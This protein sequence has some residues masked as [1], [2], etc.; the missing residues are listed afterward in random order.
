ME[1]K[2]VNINVIFFYKSN[3]QNELLRLQR[4]NKFICAM[5]VSMQELGIEG[6]QQRDAGQSAELPFH[7]QMSGGKSFL[8]QGPDDGNHGPGPQTGSLARASP[9][10]HPQG[11][12]SILRQ[13]SITSRRRGESISAMTRRFD[14]TRDASDTMGEVYNASSGSPA[15]FPTVRRT[16]ASRSRNPQRIQEE[17]EDNRRIATLERNNSSR[18][19]RFRSLHRA[20]TESDQKPRG[21]QSVI[22]RNR[23]F[24]KRGKKNSL[25]ERDRDALMEQGMAEIPESQESYMAR[26]DPRTGE[27]GSQ[28]IRTNTNTTFDSNYDWRAASKQSVDAFGAPGRSSTEA[29]EMRKMEPGA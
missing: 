22:H 11:S 5:M 13:P 2:S 27:V 26:M 6:P 24:S 14:L 25:D 3:W 28:A 9:S 23:F 21:G 16:S 17:D 18:A 29:Y 15:R 8:E 19:T 12:R 4:R 1:V 10:L 7:Y 20:S